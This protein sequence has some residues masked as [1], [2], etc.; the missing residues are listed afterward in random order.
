MY[1]APTTTRTINGPP[2]PRVVDEE[3]PEAVCP[4]E[5]FQVEEALLFAPPDDLPPDSG[6]ATAQREV[7]NLQAYVRRLRTAAGWGS[8]RGCPTRRCRSPRWISMRASSGR[9]C[10]SWRR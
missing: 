10:G 7:V 6:R 9:W 2:L 8:G 1:Y 5:G 4:P 3:G